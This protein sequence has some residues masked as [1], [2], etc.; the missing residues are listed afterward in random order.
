MRDHVTHGAKRHLDPPCGNFPEEQRHPNPRNAPRKLH[1][2]I[3]VIEDEARLFADHPADD[4]ISR[5]QRGENQIA[6]TRR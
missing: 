1:H 3:E 5:F 4:M 6:R 2:A